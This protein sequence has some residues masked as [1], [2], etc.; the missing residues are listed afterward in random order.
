MP[1]D[2]KKLARAVQNRQLCGAPMHCPGWA[3]MMAA[4]SHAIDSRERHVA[5]HAPRR[6]TSGGVKEKWASLRITN[7]SPDPVITALVQF[8]ECLST[9]VCQECGG[10]GEHRVVGSIH[11]TLCMH[12]L[13][14]WQIGEGTTALSVD[15]GAHRHEAQVR[16]LATALIPQ[17]RPPVPKRPY[18]LRDRPRNGAEGT[19]RH[20]ARQGRR[21]ILTALASPKRRPGKRGRINEVALL[22]IGTTLARADAAVGRAMVLAVECLASDTLE[23]KY[24]ADAYRDAA[25]SAHNR[26]RRA[27]EGSRRS[28]RIEDLARTARKCRRRVRRIERRL[29]R[30]ELAMLAREALGHAGTKLWGQDDAPQ[31]EAT[32]ATSALG[33]RTRNAALALYE[34]TD[35]S[36]SPRDRIDYAL[37]RR[38]PEDPQEQFQSHADPGETA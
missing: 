37:A 11:A 34:A 27:L 25:R 9:Y 3:P 31:A 29:D 35:P 7:G 36:A 16:A 8:V 23:D 19:A 38:R 21:R 18:H 6:W 12:C 28:H 32:I 15:H 5:P 26:L 13:S 17:T 1:S 33:P 20:W 22:R 14:E 30:L 10:S 4:L 2:Q 24:E